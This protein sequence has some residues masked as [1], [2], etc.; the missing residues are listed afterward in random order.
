[1]KLKRPQSLLFC[2]PVIATTPSLAAAQTNG[3]TLSEEIVVTARRKSEDVLKV[4]LAVSVL[5]GDILARTNM[6]SVKDIQYLA[7][8]LNVSTNTT[9]NSDNYTLRGQGTTFGTD[10]A[11][12]AYFAEV[13][14]AGGGGGAG[15]LFDMANVQ[16]LN[17]PQGT[18][19]GRNTTGGA[20]LFQP[21]RPTA[22]LG[23]ALE[24]GYGSDNN[25]QQQG[26]VNVPLVSDRV[27]LRVAASNRQRD[28]FTH[29]IANSRAYDNIN[30]T[31]LRV[32][33]LV[34]PVDSVENYTIV[35]Y[36]TR[37]DNGTGTK[38][39]SI[40]P[41]GA[42]GFIFGQAGLDAVDQQKGIGPRHTSLGVAQ[43]E[44]QRILTLIN[45]TRIDITSD[46]YLKN[47]ASLTH[48]RQNVAE[49]A[50]G[51]PLPI[52]DYHITPGWGGLQ[53]N[54]APAINQFTEEMQFAGKGLDQ[55]LEWTLGGYY[56]RNTPVRSLTAQQ[57]FGGPVTL[58]SIGD[59]LTSKAAFVQASVDLGKAGLGLTGLKFT[60]GYRHTVDQRR[61][62]TDSYLQVG[63][64]FNTGGPCLYLPGSYPNCRVDFPQRTFKADTYTFALDYQITPS[65]MIYATARSGFKSG[66]FNLG[67][68]PV[69]NLNSFDPEKV[70]D[71]EA[72]LKSRFDLGDI[73]MRLSLAAF[74]DKYKNI[75]RALVADFGGGAGVYV[76][77]AASATIKGVEVQADATVIR[78]F[79]LGVRYSFLDTSYD[80]FVSPQ[81]DFTG[82]PLPYTPRHKLTLMAGYDAD[83]G[84]MGTLRLNANYA[85]QSSYRN[86]DAF[87]PDIV[88]AGYGLLNL[89]ATWERVGGGP[90]DVTVY[91]TNATNKL[92]RIGGGNYYN[93]LGFTTDVYGEPRMVGINV[94]YSFNR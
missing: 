12:V 33:L 42:V 52:V 77:N 41:L 7:P 55:A 34:K 66:G 69:S 31:A 36:L 76:V 26:F 78:H 44:R 17:G 92:Y 1:M 48:F 4:P 5:S 45:T 73:G 75:Q 19:F 62:Y 84:Q 61:D 8:S 57:L 80:S 16:I 30:Y 28:G 90:F 39:A 93:T 37:T 70:D 6:T 50:D 11:V 89:G 72:G 53:N 94:K 49:D 18:L 38:L 15:M 43:R 27:L 59:R 85:Y 60:A 82:M 67:A 14:V 58:S 87:D 3:A 13:P 71:I 83:L 74:R 23:G 24:V 56:Q 20:I 29:D 79:D 25:F 54:A 86:L 81:G 21:Q 9:R 35:N 10:P 40:N 63:N 46:I 88:I 32:S 47:I 64:S 2:L 22:N 65:T 68:P 91:A 51:S